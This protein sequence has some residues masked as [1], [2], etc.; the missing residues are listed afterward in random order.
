MSFIII[1]TVNDNWLNSLFIIILFYYQIKLYNPIP[2]H[3][4][5]HSGKFT[6]EENFFLNKNSFHLYGKQTFLY[7]H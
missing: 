6:D 5:L 1:T 7:H 3:N 2:D 4:R